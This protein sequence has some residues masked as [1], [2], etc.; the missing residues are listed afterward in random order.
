MHIGEFCSSILELE[1]TTKQEKS[2]RGRDQEH[3]I[4]WGLPKTLVKP[5]GISSPSPCRK[6][7][8]L[9]LIGSLFTFNELPFAHGLHPNSWHSPEWSI[10]L[11]FHP[12]LSYLPLPRSF[13]AT[14][15]FHNFSNVLHYLLSQTPPTS[16]SSCLKCNSL[17][18]PATFPTGSMVSTYLSPSLESPSPPACVEELVLIFALFIDAIALITKSNHLSFWF[19]IFYDLSLLLD[20]NDLWVQCLDSPWHIVCFQ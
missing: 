8:L 1:T 20:L 14:W 2:G 16:S 18:S 7:V 13:L 12:H 19:F 3:A 10:L 11:V 6:N 17:T 5:S 9:H 15:L 4:T